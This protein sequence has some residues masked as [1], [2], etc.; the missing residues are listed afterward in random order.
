[1]LFGTKIAVC[2]LGFGDEGKG[3]T[4]DLLVRLLGLSYVFRFNGGS[5]PAHNV[6]APD[7]TWHCFAQF[8]SGSLNPGAQ[9][10]LSRDMLV[11]LE[12]LAIEASVLQR[13]V[14]EDVWSRLTIDPDCLLITPMQAMLGRMREIARGKDA[15][16]SCGHGVGETV[17]DAEAG[18]SLRVR[19]M[20]AGRT[21]MQRIDAIADAKIAEAARLASEHPFE[22]LNLLL[23]QIREIDTEALYCRYL[24]T[25][26]RMTVE[27]AASILR[28]NGSDHAIIGE[29]AQGA[30]LDRR[31]GFIP[32]VT[33]TDTTRHNAVVLLREAGIDEPFTLGVLRAYGHRHGAGPFV[34]EDSSLR[35]RFADPHNFENRWQGAFRVGW[36]DLLALRYGIRL[37]G[38]VDALSLT[39]LD[40]LSGLERIRV[41]VAYVTP[42]GRRFTEIPENLRAEERAA[43]VASCSPEWIELPGWS[44][45]IASVRRRDDLP[46]NARAYVRFIESGDGLATPAAIISVGPS[47]EQKIIRWS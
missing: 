31:G 3:T 24:L 41:C 26:E 7:G 12:R 33:K 17:F 25:L 16:G 22:E 10:V 38:R 14:A 36:L 47:A 19:D 13:K 37:N 11:D 9:T 4:V 42:D 46:R 30:L 29:G 40:R 15:H 6:V 20:L 44:E 8:G 35:E 18:L 5:Q 39:G 2:G 1:M 27:A 23:G 32:N 43:L 45:D 21:G 34:S 28:R